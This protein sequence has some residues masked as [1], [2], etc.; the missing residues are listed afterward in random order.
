MSAEFLIGVVALL[1]GFFLGRFS[2]RG[3]LRRAESDLPQRG[4]SSYGTGVW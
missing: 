1:T 2:L 3:R 4:R